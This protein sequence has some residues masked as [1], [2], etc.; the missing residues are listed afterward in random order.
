MH[1][2]KL[3]THYVPGM[4]LSPIEI[5]VLN[6]FLYHSPPPPAPARPHETTA[7]K[8]TDA[9]GVS[10]CHNQPQYAVQAAAGT[11]N[12]SSHLRPLMG[13]TD[14]SAATTIDESNN[15]CIANNWYMVIGSA[16]T[17]ACLSRS[18][19]FHSLL[20]THTL[21]FSPTHS[22]PH[23]HTGTLAGQPASISHSPW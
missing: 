3:T 16:L 2:K 20:F 10:T 12:A 18:D 13:G 19:C 5:H 9:K 14:N 17:P 7:K 22:P 11:K 4:R 1:N 8:H 15:G 6:T 21:S 23:P